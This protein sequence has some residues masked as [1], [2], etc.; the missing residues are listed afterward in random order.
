[1]FKLFDQILVVNDRI[2]ADPVECLSMERDRS[3]RRCIGVLG[4]LIKQASDK[5]PGL[6]FIG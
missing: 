3:E 5:R 6:V 2:I 4:I 1:M